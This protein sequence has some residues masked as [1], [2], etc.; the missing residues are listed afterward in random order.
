M[1]AYQ[2][3]EGTIEDIVAVQAFVP[4]FNHSITPTTVAERLAGKSALILVNI[5]KYYGNISTK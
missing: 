5:F 1:V 4:E 2:F 3:I